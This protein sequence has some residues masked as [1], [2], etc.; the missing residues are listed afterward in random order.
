MKYKFQSHFSKRIRDMLEYRSA[1][2]L[3]RIGYQWNLANFDRFCLK[4]FPSESS[5]TKELV[6]AWC[7]DTNGSSGYRAKYTRGFARY[8]ISTGE[9]AFLL[10]PGFFSSYKAKPPYIFSDTELRRFFE[11]ADRF[12]SY[13]S[14]TLGS[15]LLLE[16]TVPVIFRL[17][18]ACGMRP[19]EVRLLKIPD[20]NYADGTIYIAEGKH[21]KDRRLAVNPDIMRMCGNY[22]RIVAAVIPDR[23][24]FFQSP[25]GGAYSPDW[26]IAKFHQCWKMSGNGNARGTC[27]PYDFRHN[28][29]TRTLM[30]WVEEGKDL[31]SW[32]PYLSA[33]MGHVDFQSTFY[34]V[35]LLPERLSRMD[36]TRA[37]GIIPEVKDEEKTE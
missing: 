33:Y 5:L 28:Y 13:R 16:Y 21:Y 9:Q 18:Y 37:S 3:G 4:R 14:R 31:N 34:Y 8:L 22:D 35:H 6:F 2:G 26:L 1:L 30:R 17:L 25:T 29:A 20:F 10:P 12:P 36:F 19:Q 11:A 15:N 7:N 23:V 24:Y 27:N 32:I